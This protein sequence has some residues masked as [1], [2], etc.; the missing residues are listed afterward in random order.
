[1]TARAAWFVMLP[2]AVTVAIAFWA[3]IAWADPVDDSA[4]S[5]LD[6]G[7]A[8]Y[9]ARDFA[10]AVDELTQANRLVPD[11]PDPYRWLA[12][13]QAEIGECQSALRNVDAFV[14]RVHPWDS[15]VPELLALRDRCGHTGNLTIE[16]AP[17]GAT[18]RVDDGPPIGV[19]PAKRLAM[20][21]GPHTVIVEKP[22]FE[23]QSRRIDVRAFDAGN[24][25]FVLQATR[26]TPLLQRWWFWVGL[27]AVA[28]T[29]IVFTYDANRSPDPRLPVVTCSPSG[30]HP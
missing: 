19:T 12:L 11:W 23:S 13:T 9:R 8:A 16:S 15:R 18:I 17:D 4:L 6:R 5:H 25:T 2:L 28:I 22:G 29:A 21:V 20:R 7:A 14:S 30:C 26:D 27:G 1:M 24:A 10:R 3:P